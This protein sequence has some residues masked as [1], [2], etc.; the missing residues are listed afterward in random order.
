M[1]Q[2][3]AQETWEDLDSSSR[4]TVEGA[5]EAVEGAMA[6]GEGEEETRQLCSLMGQFKV[7]MCA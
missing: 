5:G 3:L 4:T 1:L 6:T 2:A 7:V